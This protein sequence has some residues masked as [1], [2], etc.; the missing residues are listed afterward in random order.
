MSMVLTMLVC[1]AGVIIPGILALLIIGNPLLSMVIALCALLIEIPCIYLVVIIW[2][3]QRDL[4]R[5]LN[6]VAA[7]LKG[8]GLP[9]AGTGDSVSVFRE[10][11]SKSRLIERLEHQFP[12]L[13]VRKALPRAVGLGVLGMVA[14]GLGTAFTGFGPLSILLLVPVGGLGCSWAVLAMQDTGQRNAFTRIFPETTDQVVRLVRAG[15]PSMEAISIVAQDA[16]PP[17]GG[18]LREV[19][20]AVA[21]GLDPETAIRS[22]AARIRIPAFSLFS[23]AVCLQMTTGGGISGALGNLSA[24]LRARHAVTLK[25]KSSTAQTRLTLAIISLVPVAVLATQNFT[26]P[27]AIETLFQTES[28]GTL[29]RYGV[30]LIL[31]GLLVARAL[32]A[33]IGR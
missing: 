23:A 4:K 3:Q 5:R 32:S 16:P 17:V 25:A 30:G 28:G 33:R 22:A 15:V 12:L 18:I 13:D 31:S 1:V 2:P 11:R 10:Q 7:T 20:S 8:G 27:Q 21:A 14:T 29:L 9:D 26:N 24:T 6:R 19:A